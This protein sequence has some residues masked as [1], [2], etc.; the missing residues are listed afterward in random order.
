M[1]AP[2]VDSKENEDEIK[3]FVEG[4]GE[5]LYEIDFFKK[6]DKILIKCYDTRSENEISYS[7]KLTIEEIKKTTS[8]YS[9]THF[10]NK[11][12][13][14]IDSLK[15]EKIGN[16]FLLHITLD[17]NKK[18]IITVKL[19]ESSEEEELEGDINNLEDAIKIIKILVKENKDLKTKL[20]YLS[21]E[22][23]EYKNNMRLNFTYNSLDINSY[24]LDNIYK[25]LSC[26]DIIQNRDEF[27]LINTGFQHIFKKNI[28]VFECIFKS[29]NNDYNYQKFSNMLNDYKYL[30]FAI[31]TKDKRR[32]GAFYENCNNYNNNQ[33]NEM[34]NNYQEEDQEEDEYPNN[35]FL[36]RQNYNYSINNTNGTLI[37]NSSSIINDYFIF[38]LNELN[39]FYCN[40]QEN[41][42]SLQF[43]I[44][45]DSN[46][47]CF[48]GR[49]CSNNNL[50]K[51]SRK[52]EFNIE[53]FEIYN[54][55]IGK[56]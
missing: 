9:T 17:R 50:F 35:I 7:Y 4:K 51:L 54:V 13:K 49:E 26:R 11:I 37:F 5:D 40:N 56:L 14:F 53:E 42:N 20:K 45:Y 12:N 55:E 3:A 10:F 48:F 6:S 19:E 16:F 27:G 23:E 41:R 8:C 43:S 46:R 47:Q 2:T 18:E 30:V 29:K 1:E 22:F 24:K 39:I 38:S 28:I 36:M 52:Q 31:F 25:T 21:N 15:I 44:F 34:N 32:F 33:I